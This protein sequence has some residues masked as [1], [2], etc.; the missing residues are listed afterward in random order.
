[1]SCVKYCHFN[2]IDLKEE[3]SALLRKPV[4]FWDKLNYFTR[5]WYVS[6]HLT[7]TAKFIEI[8]FFFLSV[9]RKEIYSDFKILIRANAQYA[10]K[11][12]FWLLR[13]EQKSW[14]ICLCVTTNDIFHNCMV[15]TTIS[16]QGFVCVC[17]CVCVCVYV[18]VWLR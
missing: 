1:M 17:V 3:Q 4:D 13:E 5:T 10:S 2:I 8:I 14:E 12:V 18:C 11:I 16:P 9:L 6:I 15:M 7:E